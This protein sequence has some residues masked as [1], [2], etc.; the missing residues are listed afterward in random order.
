MAY[1]AFA[2]ANPCVG[3]KEGVHVDSLPLPRISPYHAPVRVFI[4]HT[5]SDKHI[6]VRPLVKALQDH[7]VDPWFDEVSMRPG[8]SLVRSID[9]GLIDCDFAVIVLSPDFMKKK[10]PEY[11]FA[12]LM[13]RELHDGRKVVIPVWFNVTQEEVA[14]YSLA[15]A[16]KLAI[17]ATGKEL[18][19]VAREV[20]AVVRPSGMTSLR[21]ETN[22]PR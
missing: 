1:M 3:V 18:F 15:L 10:W 14:S 5:S 2:L 9:K 4:S 6:L 16:D 21:A 20:L 12:S 7:G 17:N 8:D 13:S 22:D 19:E 11:E